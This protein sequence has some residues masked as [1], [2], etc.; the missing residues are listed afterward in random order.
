[1]KINEIAKKSKK[2]VTEM[3]AEEFNLGI[4]AGR[5]LA[6]EFI[7]WTKQ[8]WETNPDS[9]KQAP[10]FESFTRRLARSPDWKDDFI[11]E[12]IGVVEKSFLQSI[13]KLTGKS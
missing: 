12:F 2:P 7:K 3:A 11:S 9:H 8:V 4:E 1:M 6:E 13:N 5:I 10:N